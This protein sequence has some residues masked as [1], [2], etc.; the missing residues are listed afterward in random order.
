VGQFAQC[1]SNRFRTCSFLFRL[2]SRFSLYYFS[3]CLNSRNL[4]R[5]LFSQDHTIRF[6]LCVCAC[7][8]ASL[9]IKK[10]SSTSSEKRRRNWLTHCIYN[11]YLPWLLRDGVHTRSPV[12]FDSDKKKIN[13]NTTRTNIATSVCNR[14]YLGITPND[15]EKK[16]QERSIFFGLCNESFLIER[17]KIQN[18]AILRSRTLTGNRANLTSRR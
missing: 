15:R 7:A 16:V 3:F 6:C 14:S 12:H 5:S 4:F 10:T 13:K 8:S 2:G 17:L 1:L 11:D 9:A 18:Y